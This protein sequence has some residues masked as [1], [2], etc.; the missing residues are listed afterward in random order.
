MGDGSDKASPAAVRMAMLRLMS[1]YKAIQA[2]PPSGVSASPLSEDNLF[3]W[4][5]TIIGPDESPWEGESR[6]T[7]T[8]NGRGRGTPF[9]HVRTDDNC[10]ISNANQERSDFLTHC[11]RGDARRGLTVAACYE[12]NDVLR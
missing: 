11:V 4:N 7:I 8:M 12:V 5:A 2:D 9:A 3:T 6:A 10:V 1:D